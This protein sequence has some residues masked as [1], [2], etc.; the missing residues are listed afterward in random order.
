[1]IKSN[2]LLLLLS[3]SLTTSASLHAKTD[4]ESAQANAKQAF[5]YQDAV[6]RAIEYAPELDHLKRR[7]DSAEGQIEQA[8]LRP[9]PV[10]GAEF[11]NILG[12]G[13]FDDFES[14]ET[15]IALRQKIL[16][17][18]KREL[19]TDLASRRRDELFWRRAVFV[20]KLESSVR[21]AFSVAL[22][23]SK[24][25]E[26]RREQLRLSKESLQATQKLVEAARS[27]EVELERAR[28]AVSRHRVAL[29][30]AER[31]LRAAKSKL[32]AWWG[33][34][35]ADISLK[36]ALKMPET[37]PTFS[38]LLKQLP[39]SAQLARFEALRETREA[40]LELEKAKATP[41]FEVFAAGQQF[42]EGD[43]ERAFTFGVDVPLPLFDRNQGNIRSARA[44]LRAVRSERH[45]VR[46]NLMQRL[47]RAYKQLSNAYEVAN[48]SKTDLLPRARR[49]LKATNKGYQRGQYTQLA[50]LESR[51]ALF[52]VRQRYLQA[53]GEHAQAQATIESLTKPANI[54]LHRKNTQ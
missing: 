34:P 21:E 52:E 30:E 8:S 36:G 18:D 33:E 11:E 19:R 48:S 28:L 4:V 16:T 12:T 53:L 23:A 13:R 17:A 29:Q 25:A 49:T 39:D 50:V 3:L 35:N 24:R 1:M 5:S 9:N 38:S 27:P 40:A 20:T 2:T 14:L 6:R 43:G 42:R 22:V 44:D 26:L 51:A 46:Q 45:T 47:N 31:R 41:N 7:L 37:I 10:L 32:S 15:T 54:E